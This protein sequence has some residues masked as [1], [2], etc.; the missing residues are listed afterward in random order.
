MSES[1]R[2]DI[3]AM[4]ADMRSKRQQWEQERQQRRVEKEEAGRRR[5][6]AAT[7]MMDMEES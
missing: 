5:A 1:L 3:C 4:T 6:E 7:N 2:N